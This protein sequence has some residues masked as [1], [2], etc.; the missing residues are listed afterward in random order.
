[1]LYSGSQIDYCNSLLTGI[2]EYNL[3]RLQQFVLL[4]SSD[5]QHSLHWLPVCCRIE[6]KTAT[7]SFKA[8]KLGTLYLK[9][10][11]K[12]SSAFFQYECALAFLAL[13]LHLHLVT[14]LWPDHPLDMGYCV[15]YVSATPF[16][17]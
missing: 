2:S 11:L 17:F 7:L 9:D 1:M 13:T 15:S 6:F 12:L 4:S 16:V 14:F 5:L 10:M 8:V 3:N